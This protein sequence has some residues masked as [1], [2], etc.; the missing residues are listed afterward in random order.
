MLSNVSFIILLTSSFIQLGSFIAFPPIGSGSG[1][2]TVYAENR[3]N[4]ERTLRSLNFLVGSTHKV[5][6]VIHL[7][8]FYIDLQHLW[9]ML[10]FQQSRWRNLWCWWWYTQLFQQHQQYHGPHFSIVTSLGCWSHVQGWYWMHWSIW[11]RKR[12]SQCVSTC[13]WNDVFEGKLLIDIQKWHHWL[14]W[15]PL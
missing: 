14:T 1:T 4:A 6:H 9:S 3:V 11:N 2:V 8:L 12:R 13:P 7:T 15:L 5:Y 10:L